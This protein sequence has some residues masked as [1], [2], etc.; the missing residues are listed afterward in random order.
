MFKVNDKVKVTISLD[1]KLVTGKIIEV[2][3]SSY[4]IKLDK[5]FYDINMIL[6][7]EKDVYPINNIIT[8]IQEVYV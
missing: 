4:I 8:K 3:S 1:R 6:R 7:K 5:S 2:M